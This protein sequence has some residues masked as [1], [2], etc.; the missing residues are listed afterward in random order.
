[1]SR[2]SIVKT[3]STWPKIWNRGISALLTHWKLTDS[4][5][6]PCYVQV[7][8][9]PIITQVSWNLLKYF[10]WHLIRNPKYADWKDSRKCKNVRKHSPLIVKNT[11]CIISNM[12][13]GTNRA[14]FF[15]PQIILRCKNSFLK[16]LLSFLKY[17]VQYPSYPSSRY[18]P[19]LLSS[20]TRHKRTQ[21]RLA[22][23]WWIKRASI[24]SF[25]RE[26]WTEPDSTFF[27]QKLFV[28]KTMKN[29]K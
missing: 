21:F 23:R 13:K 22:S 28:K 2:K 29:K 8:Y 11:N 24:F 3:N 10:L 18:G 25:C 14:P 26:P 20:W 16:Q 15:R 5:P 4:R 19:R 17:A 1:M 27:E 12:Y 6:D 7:F 9:S